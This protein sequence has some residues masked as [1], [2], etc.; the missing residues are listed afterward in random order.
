MLGKIQGREVR[1]VVNLTLK[2]LKSLR[3]SEL[4]G[5]LTIAA[6]VKFEIGILRW[7]SI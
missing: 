1:Q 5:M 3:H 2:H 4:D 7:R 6:R